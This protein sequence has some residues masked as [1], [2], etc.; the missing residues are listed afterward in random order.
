[1]TA[2]L[3]AIRGESEYI[4]K[5]ATENK[6]INLE[7]NDNLCELGIL[8]GKYKV[9]ALNKARS[10]IN[11]IVAVIGEKSLELCV[12]L[13]EY[14]ISESFAA[15]YKAAG[16][17]SFVAW[18]KD[19]FGMEKSSVYSKIAIGA[20]CI[21]ITAGRKTITRFYAMRV[22]MGD[23]YNPDFDFGM[24]AIGVLVKYAGIGVDGNDL[25]DTVQN[26]DSI[27]IDWIRNDKISPSMSVRQLKD[28]LKSYEESRKVKPA[29]DETPEDEPSEDE[30]PED[31]PEHLVK[32]WDGSG[33]EY[34]I[35]FE[36]LENYT[37][38]IAVTA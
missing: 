2:V 25:D 36:V 23:C 22:A 28:F 29:E 8:S 7:S 18:A 1:M 26:Q 33:A 9:A 19:A 15:D 13:Y 32:V 31:E 11:K 4:M 20:N 21:T 30:T 37:K 10:A 38:S 3:S 12:K 6:T 35:P 17:D 27:L 34:E 14:S 5:K 24:S 16:F